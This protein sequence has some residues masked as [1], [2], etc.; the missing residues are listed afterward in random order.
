MSLTQEQK[1][2]QPLPFKGETRD[3]PFSQAV[4]TLLSGNVVA[5]MLPY[6]A[7]FL[8]AR[9]YKPSAFGYFALFTSIST[10]AAIAA[11]GRYELA[12]PMPKKENDANSLALVAG[13][14][15]IGFSL[16]TGL[17]ILIA[18]LNWPS[19]KY[20]L[21]SSL[22]LPMAIL[23]I[24]IYQILS[25][26]FLRH[27][28]Y[29]TIS[30]TRFIQSGTTVLVSLIAGA[31]GLQFGLV[32]GYVTGW[33][34]G[35]GCYLILVR[36]GSQFA[37][38]P[39]VTGLKRNAILFY[40]QALYGVIPALLDS[41]SFFTII[42]II[43]HHYGSDYVGQFSL[44]RQFAY[45]PVSLIAGA[46][47]QVLLRESSKRL[48]QNQSDESL[49]RQVTRYLLAASAVYTPIL[50]IASPTLFSII[51][52]SRWHIAGELTAVLAIGYG[53]RLVVSTLSS[54]LLSHRAYRVN[55]AWQASYFLI[56]NCLYFFHPENP[57]TFF[58]TLTFFDFMLF[59]LYFIL[60]RFVVTSKYL[61]EN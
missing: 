43:N 54:L 49:F 9:L 5:Q 32:L 7:T 31:L 19:I 12:I 38:R 21:S 15:S 59:G 57:V 1:V 47:G 29:R 28:Q 10:A 45:G 40:H 30:N 14:M 56:I 44:S 22:S 16:V 46:I 17:V 51:F 36:R 33:L 55:G 20:W 52:G 50:I 11:T 23:A 42:F 25:Y 34:A 26:W 13:L 60:I 3:T 58:I 6:L 27:G 48:R 61:I 18:S 35:A 37:I 39:A 8:L 53:I 4:L 2:S 24:A 41:V